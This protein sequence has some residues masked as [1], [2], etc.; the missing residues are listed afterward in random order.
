MTLGSIAKLKVKNPKVL[1][2]PIMH[3]VPTKIQVERFKSQIGDRVTIVIK[4]EKE[5]EKT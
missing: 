2:D 4:L 5:S 1:C 3:L